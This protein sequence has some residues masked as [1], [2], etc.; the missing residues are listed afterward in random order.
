MRFGRAVFPFLRQRA[1]ADF[2]Q[3]QQVFR[4]HAQVG[5]GAGDRPMILFAVGG[6][7]PDILR[8]GVQDRNLPQLQLGGGMPAEIRLLAD[9]FHQCQPDIRCGEL[10][11]YARKTRAGADIDNAHPRTQRH[12]LQAGKRIQKM[13]GPDVFTPGDCGQVEPPVPVQKD[14]L[15]PSEIADLV[16]RE[17]DTRNGKRG[18]E[19]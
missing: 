9:G 16:F 19:E 1:S 7:L 17:G 8:T 5:H 2:H 18:L 15:K 14:F 10:E 13:L 3:R 6:I 11:R 12:R 4:Q